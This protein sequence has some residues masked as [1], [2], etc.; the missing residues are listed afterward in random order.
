LFTGN[1][2][3]SLDVDML[4][5][6]GIKDCSKLMIVAHPDD[7]TLWGGAHLYEGGWFIVCLTNGD[8]STRKKEFNKVLEVSGNKGIILSYPDLV[9]GVRSEWKTERKSIE[10]DIDTV[11]K[12]KSWGM[13]ATHNPSGEYGHIHHKLTSQLVTEI[14]YLDNWEDNLY[15]FGKWYSAQSI[16]SKAWFL[17]SVPQ[18][19]LTAKKSYLTYYSSQKG[20]V[21]RNIHMAPYENW[22]HSTEWEE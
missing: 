7:E 10:K 14:Y 19:A 6:A 8:N 11:L 12:Y 3:G 5:E 16:T 13:V 4:E 15:Y 1:D 2:K 21:S 17:D 20:V 9:N 18:A 22:I